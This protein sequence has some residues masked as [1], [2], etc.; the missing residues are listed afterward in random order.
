[1]TGPLA[2]RTVVVTRATEQAGRLVS[3]LTELGATV[4]EAPT[5]GIADP[6]DGG[7]ALAAAVHALDRY[8][9]VV[10]TSPNGVERFLRAAGGRPFHG[11]VAAVGPG[12][13]H[14]LTSAG[15]PPALVPARFVAEGLL[16]VFPPG[17]GRVLLAQAEAARPVLADGLRS[18]GWQVD[19]IVAYRTVPV[20]PPAAVVARARGADAIM[21][22]SGS[23]VAGYV[24][25]GLDA[26]PPV[27]VCIGPVTADAA[28]AAGLNVAAV[29]AEH[30]IDGLVAAVVEVLS[31]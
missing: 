25:A 26:V 31:P 13:A 22:T 5:I 1:V 21:F 2:D 11:K 18:A 29:A 16:A 15:L 6:L 4:V 23:T 17:D 12:T 30:T 27:V 10:L 9:W 20:A 14:A 28:T 8:D 24:S 3:R 19:A 7:T